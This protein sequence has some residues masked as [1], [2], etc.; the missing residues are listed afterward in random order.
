M[1]TLISILNRYNLT[2]LPID[3]SKSLDKIVRL[4]DEQLE[5]EATADIEY[6]YKGVYHKYITKNYH[7][8]KKYYKIAIDLG[9]VNA[10][11]N[12]GVYYQY[13]KNYNE[14]EKY[15]KMAIGLG[16]SHAY[17]NLVFYYKEQGYDMK[18][19]KFYI[20]NKD[21]DKVVVQFNNMVKISSENEKEYM[22]LLASYPFKEE[23][24][25]NM[26]LKLLRK[27]L[28]T[29]IDL[30]KLHFKYSVNGKGYDEAKSDFL[31]KMTK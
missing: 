3:D 22:C 29:H 28:N 24:Q 11:F 4:F 26:A 1:D 6:F 15:Y 17:A 9:N 10:M 30:M 5:F 25:L 19:L 18:L 12:L 16:H 2:Y 27:S 31:S 20:D 23:D 7:E 21:H 13:I 8:M 14:M